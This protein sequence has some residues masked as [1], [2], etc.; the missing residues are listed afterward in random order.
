VRENFSQKKKDIEQLS[1]FKTL[2][3]KPALIDDILNVIDASMFGEY[4]EL[5][6]ALLREEKDHPLLMGLAIDDS[7]QTMDEEEFRKSLLWM[8]STYYKF[9]YQ[10][11]AKDA[12]LS[13][14]KKSFLMRKIKTDIMPRLKRGELIAYESFSTI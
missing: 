3:E 9:L 1:I 6:E 7:I 13:Y 11:I 14:E 10:N 5:F 4:Q 8:L 2:L 12:T